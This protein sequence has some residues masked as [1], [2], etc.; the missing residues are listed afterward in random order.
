MEDA[1]YRARHVVGLEFGDS[2]VNLVSGSP[3]DVLFTYIVKHL[4]IRLCVLGLDS[5][6]GIGVVASGDE[7]VIGVYYLPKNGAGAEVDTGI[8]LTV[9][10]AGVPARG[11]I[12]QECNVETNINLPNDWPVLT[13]G[14]RLR[15]K[16]V[17]NGAT[18]AQAGRPFVHFTEYKGG[19]LSQEGPS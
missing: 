19:D 15:I 10:A 5:N 9:P 14:D 13:A 12:R 16:L 2:E 4:A 6:A 3:G 7:A 1:R 18:T 17:D 11:Q 8:R